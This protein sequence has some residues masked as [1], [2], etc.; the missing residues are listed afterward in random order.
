MVLLDLILFR[1]GLRKRVEKLELALEV[2]RQE[3]DVFEERA[4]YYRLRWEKEARSNVKRA[5]RG[6]ESD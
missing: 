1:R 5:M 2:M 3:R 4:D 6:P